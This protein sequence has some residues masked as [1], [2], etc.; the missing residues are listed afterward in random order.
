MN[1]KKFRDVHN[2][3]KANQEGFSCHVT[4]IFTPIKMAIIWKHLFL[5]W[6][7]VLCLLPNTGKADINF[8]CSLSLFQLWEWDV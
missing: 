8:Q 5:I 2:T 7:I 4:L 6:L 1:F 3:I